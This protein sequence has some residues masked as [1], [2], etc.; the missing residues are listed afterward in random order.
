MN[1][2]KQISQEAAWDIMEH[3]TGFQIVDVRTPEEYEA[4]HIKGAVNIHLETIRGQEI[5]QL[6]DKSQELLVYCRSGVRSKMASEKLAAQGY[7]GIEEFGGV[8]TW[9]HGLVK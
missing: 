3:G 9:T 5:P 6:P 2:Y 4:G 8:L 7:T 1:G